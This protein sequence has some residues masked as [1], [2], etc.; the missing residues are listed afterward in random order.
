MDGERESRKFL[1]STC[2]N[3]DCLRSQKNNSNIFLKN[4]PKNSFKYF[5]P[6]FIAKGNLNLPWEG[7]NFQIY[8]KFIELFVL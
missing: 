5:F 3:D 8:K 7:I 4:P 1:L 2:L 6:K